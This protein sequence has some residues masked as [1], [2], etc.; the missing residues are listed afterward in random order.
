[1]SERL[2]D[3]RK[4]ILKV[5]PSSFYKIWGTASGVYMMAGG[6]CPFCGGQGC[7]AG[8][9]AALIVGGAM[10]GIAYGS[11]AISKVVSGKKVRENRSAL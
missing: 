1:M 10:A 8:I 6:R 5:G 11:G 4:A 2:R 9:G 3:D 7:V